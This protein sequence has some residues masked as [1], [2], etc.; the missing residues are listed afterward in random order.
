MKLNA[1]GHFYNSEMGPKLGKK[2]IK[3]AGSTLS[4]G[5]MIK[6][7]SIHFFLLNEGSPQ[8]LHKVLQQCIYS[9]K[10]LCFL[11]PGVMEQL[12]YLCPH[13]HTS[14]FRKMKNKHVLAHLCELNEANRYN[15]VLESDPS[16]PCH[17]ETPQ[18]CGGCWTM[19]YSLC[20][21]SAFLSSLLSSLMVHHLCQKKGNY[22]IFHFLSLVC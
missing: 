3:K 22:H 13:M 11:V 5:Q 8:V 21:A 1:N 17:R 18:N 20:P 2:Y 16:E 12:L 7:C 19:L 14:S 6:Q 9:W 4:M 15:F 10:Y